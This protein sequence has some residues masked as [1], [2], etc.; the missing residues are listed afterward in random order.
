MCLCDEAAD[1]VRAQAARLVL[2][3][4]AHGSPSQRRA[5]AEKLL[6][7]VQSLAESGV[8]SCEF[9]GTLGDLAGLPAANHEQLDDRP[10]DGG[11]T[12][13]CYASGEGAA[14]GGDDG[15]GGSGVDV[16]FDKIAVEVT[17]L[18][19]RETALVAQ[20]RSLCV[21]VCVSVCVSLCVCV[22]RA[23]RPSEEFVCVCVCVCMCL[24]LCL[25]VPR[26]SHR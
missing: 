12:G 4:W 24:S 23:C 8:N 6:S 19:R 16:V 21:F 25:C 1:Q 22:C 20:V 18:I 26:L 11:G 3:M 10:G 14:G 9:L 7:M 17:R 13:V 15:D 5:L 2:G